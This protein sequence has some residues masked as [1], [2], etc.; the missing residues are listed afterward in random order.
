[1]PPLRSLEESK[2]TPGR[3]TDI[4]TFIRADKDRIAVKRSEGENA[5]VL[6][7]RS[8]LNAYGGT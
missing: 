8:M 3:Q 7:M 4:L 6:E 1:M 5:D 2:P